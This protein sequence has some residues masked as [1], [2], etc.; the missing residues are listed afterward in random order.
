MDW[1]GPWCTARCP[2]HRHVHWSR[3]SLLPGPTVGSGRS[4]ATCGLGT[5]A[6]LLS[7]PSPD[8]TVQPITR[9]RRPAHRPT[10]LSTSFSSPAFQPHRPA[11]LLHGRASSCPR[12]WGVRGRKRW[13]KKRAV[14]QSPSPF[15]LEA[16]MEKP[17]RAKCALT[18]SPQV[19]WPGV[20]RR[21]DSAARPQPRRKR[22]Q[23]LGPRPRQE[24]PPRPA[25]GLTTPAAS[26]TAG[27][28]RSPV[29]GDRD[30]DLGTHLSPAWR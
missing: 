21:A 15:V 7:S 25:R 29:A 24:R 30:P 19:S 28:D 26:P 5:Q 11:C 1:P 16:D 20:W 22:C 9:P 17:Q 14:C 10:P 8:P 23:R 13:L 2:R 12:P 27:P 4:W 18:V 3:T 6:S